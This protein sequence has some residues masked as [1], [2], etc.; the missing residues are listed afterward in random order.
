MKREIYKRKGVYDVQ[1]NNLFRQW[2][3]LPSIFP[4][5]SHLELIMEDEH[6]IY[7]GHRSNRARSQELDRQ[8]A[9]LGIRGEVQIIR[10]YDLMTGESEEEIVVI[11][12]SRPLLPIENARDWL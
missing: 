7:E 8:L 2:L 1:A 5:Q 9:E 3:G 11:E 4:V 10:R 6:R 12:D